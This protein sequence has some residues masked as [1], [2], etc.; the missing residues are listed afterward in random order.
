[1]GSSVRKSSCL[2]ELVHRPET[3]AYKSERA[4]GGL[5]G[6]EPISKFNKR[7]FNNG[8]IRQLDSNFIF[9][10]PRRNEIVS[11]VKLNQ[12]GFGS[13]SSVEC[14]SSLL[15]YTRSIQFHSRL[16]LK[17]QATPGLA[18]QREY[19]DGDISGDGN[20]VD[21]SFRNVSIER[22]SC[23]CN[24]RC[25]GPSGYIC[26]RVQPTV[27]LPISLDIPSSTI[28]SQSSSALKQGFGHVLSYSPSV[29]ECILERRP[30]T[31]S[32][33]STVSDSLPK[34]PSS[35]PLNGTTPTECRQLLFRGLEDT[36]W[37]R[38]IMGFQ[39]EDFLLLGSEWRDSS[40]KTYSSAWWQWISWCRQN[41]A[42]PCRPHPQ[43]V[44]SY[45]CFLSRVKKTGI[46]DYSGIQVSSSH[47]L[48]QKIV[49]V[50]LLT[51]WS[52]QF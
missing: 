31:Q 44:A 6:T 19:N 5:R 34:A 9:K 18:P 47:S 21:R 20:S 12:N 2:S 35:R 3:L 17:R 15:L 40:W 50:Y 38:L 52:L 32:R 39:N 13:G 33:K 42:E 11:H 14:E 29:G 25:T 36:G 27:A 41:G 26:K 48:F 23:L 45:L 51:L 10:K 22:G 24:D 16:P 37:A 46:C 43:K 8:S 7:T 4:L 49:T 28:N 30:E 1:M